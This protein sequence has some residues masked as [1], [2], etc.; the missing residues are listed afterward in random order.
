MVKKYAQCYWVF[1]GMHTDMHCMSMLLAEPGACC[2][3]AEVQP[4]VHAPVHAR[5]V[6]FT[7]FTHIFTARSSQVGGVL[8]GKN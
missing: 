1:S 7:V 5:S 2:V 8:L 6:V 3:H 4:A